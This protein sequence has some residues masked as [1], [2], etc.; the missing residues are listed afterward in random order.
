MTVLDDSRVSVRARGGFAVTH[1]GET[2][3]V[4]EGDVFGWTVYEGAHM[5]FVPV[6]GECPAWFASAEDAVQALL[7]RLDRQ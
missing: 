4:L 3:V 6:D 5:R 2:F 1:F 7:A